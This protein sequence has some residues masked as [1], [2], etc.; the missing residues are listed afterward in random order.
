V[1]CFVVVVLLVLLVLVVGAIGGG[2]L[3][4]GQKQKQL[5]AAATRASMFED[6]AACLSIHFPS[7]SFVK[8]V[9]PPFVFCG[10]VQRR[11]GPRWLSKFRGKTDKPG[12]LEWEEFEQAFAARIETAYQGFLTLPAEQRTLFNTDPVAFFNHVRPFFNQQFREPCLMSGL[13][14][15]PGTTS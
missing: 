6:R 13:D 5:L 1:L 2:A 14:D 4:F 12:G 8:Y 10:D 7:M 15:E 11:D 3:L 9:M